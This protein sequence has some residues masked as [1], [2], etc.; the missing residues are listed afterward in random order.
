MSYSV[1]PPRGSNTLGRK[2]KPSL[3]Y[4]GQGYSGLGRDS[5]ADVQPE[6]WEYA[7]RLSRSECVNVISSKININTRRIVKHLL[8]VGLEYLRRCSRCNTRMTSSIAQSTQYCAQCEAGV[9]WCGKEKI[10]DWEIYWSRKAFMHQ[11]PGPLMGG[12]DGI[13]T[14][15]D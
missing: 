9:P 4:E 12:G 14:L 10:E 1:A 11:V 13:G 8:S 2:R 7:E 3:E 5:G 6:T 15:D